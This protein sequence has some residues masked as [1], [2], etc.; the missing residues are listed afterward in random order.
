ME[1]IKILRSP[2]AD[3]RTANHLITEEE[4]RLSTRMHIDDVHTALDVL[5]DMLM[6]RGREHDFTKSVY[7]LEFFKQF[8]EAQKTGVW[9]KGWYDEIHIIKERHHL[10]DNCPADVNLIDV[11]EMLCDCVMAGLARTGKY[12]DEEPDAEML[13]RAYKNTVKLLVENTEVVDG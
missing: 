7:F 4:L 1:K 9:G 13:V 10:K 6:Q 12:R 3:T 5:A 2:S 11:L 8:H